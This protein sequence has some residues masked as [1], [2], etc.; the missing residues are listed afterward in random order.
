MGQRA[1]AAVTR[2]IAKPVAN[3]RIIARIHALL[4]KVKNNITIMCLIPGPRPS[5]MQTPPSRREYSCRPTSGAWVLGDLSEPFLKRPFAPLT[6]QLLHPTSP[7][8][9]RSSAQA[10]LRRICGERGQ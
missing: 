9:R 10:L 2:C 5:G 3:K 4:A 6:A 8:S 1:G 7:P